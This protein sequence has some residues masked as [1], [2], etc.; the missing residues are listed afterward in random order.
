MAPPISF[1]LDGKQY[2]AQA[3]G[4]GGGF[5]A[6][7]GVVAHG[8]KVPNI[9]R[10]LVFALGANQELPP[11]EVQTR[12]LPKPAPATASAETI[13]RGKDVYQRHCAYCHGDG[14]RTGG[15]NPDLRYSPPEV[16]AIWQDIVRGGVL[17]ERGMVSFAQFV[18]E[19]EAEA[20]RQYVLAEAN[21]LWGEKR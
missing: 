11:R 6:E 3:V 16:H 19:E 12:P 8:W 4:F 18:S 10:V 17:K 5:A 1:S 21:R 7:G 2:I 20:V 13:A 14:L 15:L 9:P